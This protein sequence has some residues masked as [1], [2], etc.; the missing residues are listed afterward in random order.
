M[1]IG[2]K[3]I[4]QISHNFD[5]PSLCALSRVLLVTPW[6]EA[7]QTPL[8]MG[9]S[10]QERWSDLPSPSNPNVAQEPQTVISVG[11]VLHPTSAS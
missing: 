11:P 2:E 4:S 10:R 5:K 6:T 9:F 3:Q 1:S 7:H 8:Y